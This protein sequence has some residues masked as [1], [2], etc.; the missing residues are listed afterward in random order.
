M[1][2]L[3]RACIFIGTFFMAASAIAPA[4]QQSPLTIYALRGPYG[5]GMVRLFEQPPALPGGGRARMEALSGADILVNE[6]VGGRAKIGILPPNYAAKIVAAGRNIQVAAV[7]G[8]GMLKLLTSDTDIQ[9]LPDLRGK[10]VEISEQGSVPDYVFHRVL[11]RYNLKAGEDIELTYTIP[12][13][14]IAQAL[15]GGRID[16]AL[17]PEPYATMVVMSKPSIRKIGDI[18]EEWAA[19]GGE[20]RYPMSVLVVDADYAKEEPMAVK[21][22]AAAIKASIEWVVTNPPDAGLLAEKYALG[23]RRAVVIAGVPNSNYVYIPSSQARASIESL[24]NAVLE[25]APE[26]IG[27]RLPDSDFYLDIN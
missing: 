19:T 1:K 3:M 26:S 14:D 20:L 9:R 23:M 6:F 7:T 8:T 4:Q 5:I 15:I 11:N 17:V 22:I 16:T 27:G 12:Y 25:F 13:S 21:A 18:Q 24:L 10:T 2:K